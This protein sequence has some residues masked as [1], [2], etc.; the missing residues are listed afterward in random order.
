ML[1]HPVSFLCPE[2][3]LKFLPDPVVKAFRSQYLNIGH[4]G[5]NPPHEF[6]APGG[7]HPHLDATITLFP[8]LLCRVPLPLGVVDAQFRLEEQADLDRG[9]AAHD[10]ERLPAVGLGLEVC[11]VGESVAAGLD[12]AFIF[13]KLSSG[14]CR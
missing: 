9:L 10:P 11:G 4:P 7:F 1:G 5:Q 12:P 13:L 3:I 14:V 8:E 6:L 2:S